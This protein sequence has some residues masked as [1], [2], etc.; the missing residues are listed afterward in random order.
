MEP[1]FYL[2]DADILQHERAL[3]MDGA[4]F[5]QAFFDALRG[6]GILADFVYGPNA[7]CVMSAAE[8]VAND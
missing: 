5:K 2:I 8:R 6:E 7:G 3:L 1:G 4:E